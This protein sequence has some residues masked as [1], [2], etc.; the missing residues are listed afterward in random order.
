MARID[1]T[2]ADRKLLVR[3]DKNLNILL[4]TEEELM[5]K[6]DD[7]VIAV[8]EQTTVVASAGALLD[9]LTVAISEL[10]NDLSNAGMD[11][12]KVDAV[13][14]QIATNKQAL[15]D[16]VA[17]NTPAEETEEVPPV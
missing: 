6:I 9:G 12:T 7:L 13:M 16:A 5:S 3:I 11:T 15:S 14:E 2:D 10:R 8:S 1:F 4:K 17:R